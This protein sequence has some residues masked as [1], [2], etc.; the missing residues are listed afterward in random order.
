MRILNPATNPSINDEV[1]KVGISTGIVLP[2][3][4]LWNQNFKKKTYCKK[5]G[6]RTAANL[7]NL[8][9]EVF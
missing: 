9:D 1:Q 5:M 4:R 6:L 8:Q 3:H 2:D 7:E